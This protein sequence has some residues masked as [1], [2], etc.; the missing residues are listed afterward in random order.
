MKKFALIILV[1]FLASACVK[2]PTTNIPAAKINLYNKIISVGS[3][4]INVEI[5]SSDA[6]MQKGLSGRNSMADNEGMLFDFTSKLSP[7]LA[8]KGEGVRPT[9]W[10]KDMNFDIDLIWIANKKVV[11]IT[12]NV[13]APKSA[14][15]VLPTYSPPGDV[16]M[17]LEVNAGWSKKYE[18]RVGDELKFN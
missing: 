11:G 17:V 6:D 3:K 5:V 13:T 12:N 16:D 14:K 9:F 10:M 15:D 18:V 4:K 1:L 2:S 8:L 7:T